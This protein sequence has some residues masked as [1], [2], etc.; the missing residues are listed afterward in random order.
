MSF[1]KNPKYDTFTQQYQTLSAEQTG[2]GDSH[3]SG[4]C[5]CR[6]IEVNSD[7]FIRDKFNVICSF[8]FLA[9]LTSERVGACPSWRKKQI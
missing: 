4:G 6:N 5:L 1:S 7:L 8:E 3:Y 9:R 2:R